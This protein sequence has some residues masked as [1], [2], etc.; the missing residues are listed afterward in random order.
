MNSEVPTLE[1]T[2]VITGEDLFIQAIDRCEAG[3]N[4]ECIDLC[5]QALA[6]GHVNAN[7]YEQIGGAYY[8]LGDFNSARVYI[9]MA[10]ELDPVQDWAYFISGDIKKQS[11]DL[12]GALVDFHKGIEIDPNMFEL[13]MKLV[14]VYYELDDLDEAIAALDQA[15]ELNQLT[16]G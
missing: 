14:E 15:Y 4:Q 3:Q 11:G 8:N 10:I 13:Y 1:P 6:A 9:D 12:E 16:L 7:V 5:L 2:A